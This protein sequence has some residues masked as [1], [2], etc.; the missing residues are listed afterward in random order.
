M[1]L[2]A[3]DSFSRLK[4]LDGELLSTLLPTVLGPV[5]SAES[6]A[7]IC[8]AASWAY[9]QPRE[10]AE[11]SQ[12]V[13]LTK[14]LEKTAWMSLSQAHR[15]ILNTLVKRLEYSKL[16]QLQVLRQKGQTSFQAWKMRGSAALTASLPLCVVPTLDHEMASVKGDLFTCSCPPTCRCWHV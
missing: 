10:A 3:L 12:T 5:S 14:E 11:A 13:N 2:S 6:L 8:A 16:Q 9:K 4:G 15:E 1:A 7:Q